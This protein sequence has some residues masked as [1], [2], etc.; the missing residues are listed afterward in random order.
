MRKFIILLIVALFMS[1]SLGGLAEARSSG[2]SRTY[3]TGHS[4]ASSTRVKGYTKKN[5]TYVQ[6]HRRSTADHTKTNN[7]STKGN[8]NPYTGKAGTKKP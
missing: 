3:S 1:F 4:K 2:S 5:G 8:R 6:S 7:W